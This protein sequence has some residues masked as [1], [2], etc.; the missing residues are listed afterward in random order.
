MDVVVHTS[1]R[2]GLARVLPQAGAVGKPVV[3]FALDGAPEVVRDGVSGY[4]IPP[5]DT[6]A[7]ADRVV[8]L[9]RDPDRRARFGAAGRAF[10]VANFGVDRM[11]ARIDEVYE[12][13]LTAKL[14][15][16][17]TTAPPRS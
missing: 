10:A 16:M 12:R 14:P 17:A 8:E 1:L 9:L 2:E 13:L 3:T 7:L 5:L 4:L 15:S 11:V 6:A